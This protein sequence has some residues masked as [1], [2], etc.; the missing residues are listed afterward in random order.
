MLIHKQTIASI[1]STANLHSLR[2]FNEDKATW[3]GLLTPCTVWTGAYWS[4]SGDLLWI[5]GPCRVVSANY[6]ICLLIYSRVHITPSLS[7]LDAFALSINVW[8]LD[9]DKTMHSYEGQHI[10]HLTGIYENKTLT[11]TPNTHVVEQI[12]Q[13]KQ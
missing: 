7:L 6:S 13:F 9:L 2:R 5:W 1:L 8:G 11:D 12:S 4:V 3:T 10:W